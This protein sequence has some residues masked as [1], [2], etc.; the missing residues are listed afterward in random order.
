VVDDGSDNR[1]ALRPV[2]LNAS[3]E[4]MLQFRVPR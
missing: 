3:G 1:D 2:L 4:F